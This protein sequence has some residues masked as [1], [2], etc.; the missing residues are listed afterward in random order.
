[1]SM[2]LLP[3]DALHQLTVTFSNVNPEYIA[4]LLEHAGQDTEA[5]MDLLL[6]GQD[7]TAV[8][9][10]RPC[11][12]FLQG[13]CA[14]RDCMFSHEVATCSFWKGGTCAKG[15][16][17]AFLHDLD[18]SHLTRLQKRLDAKRPRRTLLVT[19]GPLAL[20]R[21]RSTRCTDRRGH[22][23]RCLSL[24]GSECVTYRSTLPLA[25][26][27]SAVCKSRSDKDGRAKCHWTQTQLASE[28]PVGAWPLCCGK[29]RTSRGQRAWC[30]TVV[31][32]HR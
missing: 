14:R 17:C 21:Y 9:Q 19:I 24:A 29:G 11:R 3:L 2:S 25:E 31:G 22:G 32:Q 27:W 6:L 15:D 28:T 13:H 20:R 23:T 7:T 8:P 18:Q 30:I 16:S 5:V 4:L 10:Q 1:M 26:L 12:H